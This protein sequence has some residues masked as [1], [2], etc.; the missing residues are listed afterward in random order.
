MIPDNWFACFE[1]DGN[2]DVQMRT[3]T[4]TGGGTAQLTIDLMSALRRVV[5]SDNKIR[6]LETV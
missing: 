6:I 3:S 1:T 4:T 2:G 5:T